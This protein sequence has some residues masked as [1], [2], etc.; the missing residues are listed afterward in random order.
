LQRSH[1]ASHW[2]IGV[3]AALFVACGLRAQT[4]IVESAEFGRSIALS[5]A[6]SVPYRREIVWAVLTDYEHMP[7]YLSAVKSSTIESRDGNRLVVRQ[8]GVAKRGLMS[9]PFSTK[10]TVL[11]VPPSQIQTSLEESENFERYDVRTT[12]TEVADATTIDFEATIVP[13]SLLQ[14][15]IGTSILRDE[16]SRQYSELFA[17]MAKQQRLDQQR[18]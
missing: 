15:L 16:V 6:V 5:F 14:R 7:S 18:R 9:F 1:S 12:L 17:E 10:R 4:I 8:S 2:L 3:W 13:S 11:L